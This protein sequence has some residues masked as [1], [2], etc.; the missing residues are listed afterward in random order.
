MDLKLISTELNEETI[1]VTYTDGL[2]ADNSKELL[3]VRGSFS[4]DLKKS[5]LWNQMNLM[6]ELADWSSAEF[7]RL[8][9]ELETM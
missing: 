2:P 7:R 3:V 9:N 5:F 1:Q 4:G 6:Q 8:R